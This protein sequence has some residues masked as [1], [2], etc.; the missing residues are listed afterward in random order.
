MRK[1]FLAGLGL[2]LTFSLGLANRGQTSNSN[3][4]STQS[5]NNKS[6][7]SRSPFRAT[8]DQIKQAQ[9]ILKQRGFYSGE[10]SGKWNPATRAALVNYQAAESLR[11]TGDL[12]RAT[13]TKMGIALTADQTPAVTPF[14]YTADQ[15]KQ[16]QAIL[17]QRGFYSG[18]QTGKINSDTRAAL[19]KYQQAEGLNVTGNLNRAT[20]EK[21]GIALT[22]DQKPK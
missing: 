6:T 19:V 21:M 16:A 2:V 11:A 1:L 17:K 3:S 9:G 14:H 10:E 12:D 18:E 22:E 15:V 7:T 8:S 4:N 13:V 5:N 20:L